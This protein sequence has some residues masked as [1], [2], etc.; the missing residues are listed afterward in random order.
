[1]PEKQRRAAQTYEEDSEGGQMSDVCSL[2]TV[3]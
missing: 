3:W 1:V 2:G